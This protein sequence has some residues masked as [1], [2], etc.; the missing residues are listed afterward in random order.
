MSSATATATAAATSSSSA[1]PARHTSWSSRLDAIAE[2]L[3]AMLHEFEP[4]RCDA[5]GALRL[6][7]LFTRVR[8]A[9]AAG[10][11]LIARRADECG[12]HRRTGHRSTAHLLA[13]VGGTTIGRATEIVETGKRVAE[14]PAS[15]AA[16][17]AGTVSIE[18]AH[19]VTA[20]AEADP[21]AESALLALAGRESVRRL[22]ERARDVRLGADDDRL[23]RYRRQCAARSLRH[24]RD[25]DGMVWGQFRLPPDTGAAVINRLERQADR[26]FRTARAEGR[27]EEHDRYLADA[28]V[29]LT[30]GSADT[31]GDTR[32]DARADVIVHVSHDALV[33]GRVED[34][35]RCMIQGVG[36]IPVEAAREIMRDAFL[37]GVLVDG[38]D[39]VKI[40]H[41]GR[42]RSAE[43]QTALEVR[44]VARDGDVTCA[45]EGCDQRLGLEWDH[46]HPHAAGGPTS[47]DNLR[48][49]C[50]HHHRQK[51]SDDA[52]AT[53]RGQAT[54]RAPP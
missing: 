47:Y 42:R 15:D 10:E 18:Q 2:Q 22:R 41:F 37:K 34:G 3:D 35:E 43:L 48:P 53:S 1:A 4:E 5:D 51:S 40:R 29:R 49:L 30:T 33:R 45:H 32:A 27:R 38:T 26:E 6:L 9:A 28:L 16:L 50:R 54:R 13:E 44:A 39:V 36:P 21:D 14:R 25:D 46:E 19:A 12:V 17:R 52:R 24:G 8:K 20:A 11:A 31:P 7:G 23:G